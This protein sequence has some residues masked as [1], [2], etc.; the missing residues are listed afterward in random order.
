DGKHVPRRKSSGNDTCLRQ[1]SRKR[2]LPQRRSVAPTLRTAFPSA[3]TG[4]SHDASATWRGGVWA[5]PA[6]RVP[7]GGP[8]AEA[9]SPVASILRQALAAGGPEAAD[10]QAPR[11]L[12]G[13]GGRPEAPDREPEGPGEEGA[14]GGP[15]AGAAE[16]PAPAAD[17]REGTGGAQGRG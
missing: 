14:G 12:Q 1:E 5:C 3:Q 11:R 7:T 4:T 9:G 10:S 13:Q 2:C 15:D 17:R 16:A 6:A 8:G